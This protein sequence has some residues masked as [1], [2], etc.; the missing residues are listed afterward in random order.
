MKLLALLVLLAQAMMGPPPQPMTPE[1]FAQ[2]LPGQSVQIAVRVDRVQ[3][4]TLYV[5]LL[6]HQTDTLAKLTPQHVVLYFGS[7][8][9]VVMG[10]ADDVTAGA[11]LFV[12][13][14]VTSANHVDAK[15]VVVDTKYVTVE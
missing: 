7:G 15:R 11:A 13:G 12:Y 5:T 4:S 14:V 9:P 6:R 8:T 2:A 10:S 1:Q 3:R